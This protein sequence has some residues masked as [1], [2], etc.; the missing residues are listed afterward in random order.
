MGHRISKINIFLLFILLIGPAKTYADTT[1]DLINKL[2][3]IESR[4]KVLEKATFNQTTSD[5]QNN[6]SLDDY[7]SI[8]TKQ[9]I[10]I[11]EIQNEIQSLTSQ[12]EEVLFTLQSTINSLNTFREDTEFRFV[13]VDNKT[14]DE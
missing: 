4:I 9:S 7:Q 10:Q 2:N 11:A 5:M 12:L 3:T 6:V 1:E 8:I 13:D 14:N